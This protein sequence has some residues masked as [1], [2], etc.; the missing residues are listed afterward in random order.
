MRMKR[1]GIEMKLVI[2]G[3]GPSRVDQTLLK[4]IVRAH[5]WFNDLATEKVKN[6]AEI[7]SR[8][9]I[10]KSHVSRVINLVFLAPD[11]VESIIAGQQPADLNVEKLTKRTDLP[12]DWNQQRQ[13][14][15]T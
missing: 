4:T 1:R 12:L 2:N 10:D 13:L 8:E 11:I 5:R 15:I 3:T 6:M 9:K 7:A 14:L